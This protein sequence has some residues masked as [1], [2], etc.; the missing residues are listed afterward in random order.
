M[1]SI[2]IGGFKLLPEERG[3]AETEHDGHEEEEENVEPG[4][5]LGLQ[6]AGPEIMTFISFINGVFSAS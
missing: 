1:P 6:V 2:R 3:D 5:A 4:R